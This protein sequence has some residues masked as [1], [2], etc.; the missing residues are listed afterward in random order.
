M[1]IGHLPLVIVAMKIK[2]YLSKSTVGVKNDTLVLLNF[3]ATD[4]LIL[5]K[6]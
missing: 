6:S 4:A 2:I 5:K 1:S 3:E